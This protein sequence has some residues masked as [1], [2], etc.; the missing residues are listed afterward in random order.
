MSADPDTDRGSPWP[1]DPRLRSRIRQGACIRQA[2]AAV[3]LTE[4][5]LADQAEHWPAASAIA[6]AVEAALLSDPTAAGELAN[7]VAA[8]YD[9][10]RG[11][12]ASM[13][14]Q[15]CRLSAAL[16]LAMADRGGHDRDHAA[17][18]HAL[19]LTTARL[20][21][22]AET[23]TTTATVMVEPDAERRA[24][25]RAVEPQPYSPLTM[26]E[27]EAGRLTQTQAQR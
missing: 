15:S 21:E 1:R 22:I 4:P 3:G 19:T 7:A 20:C 12:G 25:G 10:G 8:S 2:I 26:A 13:G 14:C 11:R 9:L 18:R 5:E 17:M 23:Q 27:V 24:Q 16:W 6:T